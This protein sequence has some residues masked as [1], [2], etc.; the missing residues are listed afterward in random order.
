[1]SQVCLRQYPKQLRVKPVIYV[2]LLCIFLC[3]FLPFDFSFVNEEQKLVMF[4]Y[5]GLFASNGQAVLFV[6]L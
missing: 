5:F 6:Y 3:I 4:L 1:M 2:R